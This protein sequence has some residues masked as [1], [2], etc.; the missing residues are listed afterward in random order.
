MEQFNILIVQTPE[1]PFYHAYTGM[2]RTLAAALKRLGHPT[3]LAANE[4]VHDAT[5]IVL[6]AHN[7]DSAVADTLPPGTIIYNSE[8]ALS[9]SPFLPALKAFV[10]RFETW[11]YSAAN[12]RAWNELGVSDRVRWLRPGYLPECTTIDPATETDIDLLFYGHVNSRRRAILD[13]LARRDIRAY[14]LMNTYGDA[15]D[16]YI[17]RAKLV[18]NLHTTPDAVFEIARAVP[19]LSNR[20]ALVSEAGGFDESVGDLL[21]GIAIGETSQLPELCRA[22]LDDD[23]RRKALAEAGFELFSRRDFVGT[24]RDALAARSAA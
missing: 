15:R 18:L 11:D 24:V 13:A 20:R 22:L 8:M 23:A 17:A 14:V 6:G 21:A 12:V 3:R 5:N 7:L 2:A 19:V 4:L 16:A 9:H 1:V 10:G